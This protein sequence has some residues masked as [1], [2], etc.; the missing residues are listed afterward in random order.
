M[1]GVGKCIGV[2]GEV[3]ES[4]FGMWE[5]CWGVGKYGEVWEM[6]VGMWKCVWGVGKCVW[7]V[8]K[9]VEVGAM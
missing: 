7:D 6:G 9:G 3:S 2:W 4:V 8:G 5:V 1:E